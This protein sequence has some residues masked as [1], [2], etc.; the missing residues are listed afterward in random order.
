MCCESTANS[1]YTTSYM[2]VSTTGLAILLLT[3]TSSSSAS[4]PTPILDM[5]AHM[6]SMSM[7]AAVVHDSDVGHAVQVI[8]CGAY[9]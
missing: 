7:L 2:V 1:T 4:S 5:L 6:L 9:A 3:S 8:A